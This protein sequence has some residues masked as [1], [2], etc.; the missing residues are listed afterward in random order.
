MNR[1][2]DQLAAHVRRVLEQAGLTQVKIAQAL[3]TEQTLISKRYRGTISWRAHELQAISDAFGIPV[4]DLYLPA[5]A[6]PVTA[7]PAAAGTPS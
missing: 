3:G 7:E 4:A 1:P 2:R 6:E 5:P